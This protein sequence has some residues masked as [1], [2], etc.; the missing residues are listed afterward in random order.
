MLYLLLV[1]GLSNCHSIMYEEDLIVNKVQKGNDKYKYRYYLEA[2]P[3]DQVLF[4]NEI[5]HVGDT[6]KPIINDFNFR[7]NR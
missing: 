5:Y 1:I 7:F 3:V 4:S 2:F 6:L